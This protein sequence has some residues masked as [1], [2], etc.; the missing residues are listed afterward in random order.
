MT[1]KRRPGPIPYGERLADALRL[2]EAIRTEGLLGAAPLPE[3]GSG[4]LR[5]ESVEWLERE[6]DSSLPDELLAVL[7]LRDPIVA[8][9]TGLSGLDAVLDVA[10]KVVELDDEAFAGTWIAVSRVSAEPF[11]ELLGS[12]HGTSQLELC[13]RKDADPG[14]EAELLVLEDDRPRQLLPLGE[15]I[16]DVLRSELRHHDAWQSAL[17]TERE[18]ASFRPSAELV[19]DRPA[20]HEPS[21]RVHHQKFGAGRVVESDG[22]GPDAKLTVRF[23][24]GTT[25]RLLARYVEP[26]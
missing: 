23:A 22:G 11:T 5:L 24:D 13:V 15:L 2:C 26:A 12:A 21:P 14:G 17:A 1:R 19:E 6:L 25:R 8:V 10:E 18:L 7:A 4:A 9:A 20:R 16:G 3:R